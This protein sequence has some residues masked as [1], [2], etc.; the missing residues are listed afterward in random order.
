MKHISEMTKKQSDPYKG[1]SMIQIEKSIEILP[2]LK[3]P[4][5]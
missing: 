1:C 4:E 2:L 5:M 3:D